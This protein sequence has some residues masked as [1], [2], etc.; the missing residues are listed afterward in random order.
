MQGSCIVVLHELLATQQT[1][2]I[3]HIRTIVAIH[4][5][6]KKYKHYQ[7]KTVVFK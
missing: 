4:L 3:F 6:K 2:N 5:L 7:T 1:L